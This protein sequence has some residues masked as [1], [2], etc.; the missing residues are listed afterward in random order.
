MNKFKKLTPGQ[1]RLIAMDVDGVL[2]DG[3]IILG[4]NGFEAKRFNS[5]DGLGINVL[6]KLGYPVAWV[7]GRTSDIVEQRARELHITHLKQGMVD[8]VG[9]IE[10]LLAGLKLKWE[11][12]LYIGDDLNDWGPFQKAAFTCTVHNGT[13]E[14][15]RKADYITKACGGSGAIREII[16]LFLKHEGRW[17]EALALYSDHLYRY[18]TLSK[19]E[20]Q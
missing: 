8:K 16:E 15:K 7:T 2:T 12:V 3:A 9:A 14:I 11:N 5:Q 18:Q 6:V 17:E 1:I 10:E 13:S 19:G 4:S 20:I